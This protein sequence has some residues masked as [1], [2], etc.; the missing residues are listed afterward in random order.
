MAAVSQ[1]IVAST[2]CSHPTPMT[3]STIPEFGERP[4]AGRYRTVSNVAGPHSIYIN[5]TALT[6]LTGTTRSVYPR[7]TDSLRNDSV[8]VS[9]FPRRVTYKVVRG[10]WG[11]K[12]PV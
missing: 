5:R 3:F 6:Y 9:R 7:D 10:K 11:F 12:K 8:L 2:E 1:L 4:S